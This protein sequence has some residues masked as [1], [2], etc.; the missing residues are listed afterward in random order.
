MNQLFTDTCS[1]LRDRQ[2]CE[3]MLENKELRQEIDIYKRYPQIYGL[4]WSSC[5]PNTGVDGRPMGHNETNIPDS[6][7]MLC[8]LEFESNTFCPDPHEQDLCRLRTAIDSYQ[9]RAHPESPKSFIRRKKYVIPQGD[10]AFEVFLVC[11]CDVLRKFL[12]LHNVWRYCTYFRDTTAYLGVHHCSDE[13]ECLQLDDASISDPEA[14]TASTHQQ[15]RL[16]IFHE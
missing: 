11:A 9:M 3:L 4:K 8:R 15:F 14:R 12:A 7:S 2:I 6:R 1:V 10:E 16:A 5:D 13:G